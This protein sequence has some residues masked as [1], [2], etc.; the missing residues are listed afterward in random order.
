MT[1][2]VCLHVM[3]VCVC[4]CWRKK[5]CGRV[6]FGKYDLA[7]PAV[8]FFFF[9]LNAKPCLGVLYYLTAHKQNV[10]ERSGTAR[11]RSCVTVG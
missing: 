5:G 6:G 4:V 1:V 8:V 11:E 3:C 9:F 10:H 2:V 7:F